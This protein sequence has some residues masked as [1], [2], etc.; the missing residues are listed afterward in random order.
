MIFDRCERKQIKNLTRDL[1]KNEI[2]LQCNEHT[3]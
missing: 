2:D 3:L 1:S